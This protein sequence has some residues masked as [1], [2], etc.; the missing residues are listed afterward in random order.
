MRPHRPERCALPD[1][2][3]LRDQR[4]RYIAV[5]FEPR[6]G[7]KAATVIKGGRVEKAD[8][9]SG[10]PVAM[11]FSRAYRVFNADQIEGLP[12]EFHGQHI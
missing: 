7:E 1:C 10:E 9:E 8:K 11:P 12:E 2:A 6:K 3:T 5:A 4:A